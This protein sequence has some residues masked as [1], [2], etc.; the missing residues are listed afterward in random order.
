[1]LPLYC[2]PPVRRSLCCRCSS[3]RSCSGR[4]QS[5]RWWCRS[6]PPGARSWGRCRSPCWRSS[7]RRD[8]RT[9]RWR[10]CW[11]SRTEPGCPGSGAGRA[12]WPARC[13]PPATVEDLWWTLLV[14]WLSAL[15]MACLLLLGNPLKGLCLC[16]RATG[17][18]F[19]CRSTS[20][21]R[22]SIGRWLRSSASTHWNIFVW[23]K[24]CRL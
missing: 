23:C 18:P 9:W 15:T 22:C 19:S 4:S 24:N 12:G 13:H 6:P 10:G 14:N 8:G 1:M 3:C 7:R 16:A 20:P 2:S 11:S 17:P 21:P 5:W